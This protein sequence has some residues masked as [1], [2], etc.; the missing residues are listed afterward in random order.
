MAEVQE[1]LKKVYGKMKTI[2]SERD[3]AVKREKETAAELSVVKEERDKAE[4]EIK[5]L[6]KNIADPVNAEEA[7]PFDVVNLPS[8]F[9]DLLALNW[10]FMKQ[11]IRRYFMNIIQ[12][13]IRFFRT[14]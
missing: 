9:T 12:T 7:F 6:Q 4:E 1:E 14:N 10:G 13:I 5:R 8:N 3:Q 2:D 11:I